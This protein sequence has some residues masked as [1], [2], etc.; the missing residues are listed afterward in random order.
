MALTYNQD[1]PSV[2]ELKDVWLRIPIASTET[3][4]LTKLFVR[5][6]T[7]GNLKRS[8]RGAEIVALREIN[9]VIRHGERVALLGHNGAGKSTFLRL[10]SG[11]YTPSQGYYQRNAEIF[12]LISKRFL[13][14][15]DLTGIDAAKAHYLHANHSL[16][17]F[18]KFLQDVVEFSGIGSF[19]ELPVRGYS[20]GMG[21]RLLFS[22]ITSTAHDCLAIDE[23]LG[24]ADSKFF[25]KAQERMN[26]FISSAGTLIFA[27]HSHILLRKFCTRGLVFNQGC[28]V[29]DAPLEDAI[30]FYHAQNS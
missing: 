2:L 1:S 27:S 30:K 25:D 23:G 5:S 22:L 8:K 18:D 13:T 21:A 20:S 29:C 4:S 9:C 11:I 14:S 15:P 16:R 26:T 17:G 10:A 6:V 7:G 19:I 24:A 28:I 12:P 3:R